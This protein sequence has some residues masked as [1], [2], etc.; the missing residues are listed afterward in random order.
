M[1]DKNLL[2]LLPEIELLFPPARSLKIK[3]KII[4]NERYLSLE[5]ALIITESYKRTEGKSRALQR[6][7]ALSDSLGLIDIKIDQEEIL[8]GNRTVGIRDGVVFPEAGI[9]WV[10]KEIDTLATREQD[11][12]SVR[13]KDKVDF[14]EQIVPYWKGKTLQSLRKNKE[15]ITAWEAGSVSLGASETQLKYKQLCKDQIK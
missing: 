7:E 1:E 12:F 9:S 2:S 8:V 10:E 5:Q 6:A 3:D 15:A 4:N 14:F 13:K 11:K